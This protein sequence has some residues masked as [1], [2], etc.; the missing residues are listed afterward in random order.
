METDARQERGL[1][2]AK[3]ARIDRKDDGTWLVPSMSG[4]GRYTVNV[5]GEKPTCTC[6]DCEKGFTCKHIH[7]VLIVMKRETTQNVDG[8]TTVTETVAIKAVKRTNYSQDWPAYNEAQTNEQD[9]FRR[10][11]AD[12]CSG[13]QTGDEVPGICFAHRSHFAYGDRPG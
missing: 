1:A 12:L 9:E 7:A 13:I 2:I 4:N 3:V 5:D 6:P 10:L 8:S 11:L